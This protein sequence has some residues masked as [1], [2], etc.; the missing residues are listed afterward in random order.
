MKFAM[1]VCVLY[2][3]VLLILL[4]SLW[5]SCIHC[6]ILTECVIASSDFRFD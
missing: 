2:A 5:T 4:Q 6:D 1:A 3:V